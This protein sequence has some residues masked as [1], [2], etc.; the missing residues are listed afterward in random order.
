MSSSSISFILLSIALF[1]VTFL[2]NGF[3]KSSKRSSNSSNE[4]SGSN[5][6]IVV[7]YDY[8][9][10]TSE[11]YSTAVNIIRKFDKKMKNW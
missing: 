3:I 8:S 1:V 9:S 6:S 7:T 2:F 4:N 5:E 11:S 10:D